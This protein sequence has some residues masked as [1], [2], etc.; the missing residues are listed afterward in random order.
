MIV[1]WVQKPASSSGICS[2]CLLLGVSRRSGRPLSREHLVSLVS[3]ASPCPLPLPRQPFSSP[4]PLP[5]SACS[6]PE[7]GSRELG[8][9][10]HGISSSVKKEAIGEV[11]E[12]GEERVDPTSR[13]SSPGWDP[14]V[15]LEGR[16]ACSSSPPPVPH[17]RAPH[18]AGTLPHWAHVTFCRAGRTGK[19]AART[20]VCSVA[21]C[22]FCTWRRFVMRFCRAGWGR[23]GGDPGGMKWRQDIALCSAEGG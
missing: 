23:A 22:G 6:S 9:D 12:S 20:D 3:H 1:L 21:M 15:L 7:R 17:S 14:K 11:S 5:S 18:S 16:W 13:G 10:P 8:P 4:G 19:G 2:G